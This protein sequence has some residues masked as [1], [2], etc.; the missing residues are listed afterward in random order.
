MGEN[1]FQK[2]QDAIAT[3]RAKRDRIQANA[4]AIA[5]ELERV[6]ALGDE[7]M[8]AEARAMPDAQAIIDRFSRERTSSLV[9]AM[10]TS[11][12]EIEAIVEGDEG[13]IGD[14]VAQARQ[15]MYV[16]AL[17]CDELDRRVPVPQ[18]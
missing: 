18:K 1:P 2:S 17:L 4:E 10:V 14:S 12:A 7:G 3:L 15:A 6:Q 11:R 5:V 9:G 13:A 16:L 8:L